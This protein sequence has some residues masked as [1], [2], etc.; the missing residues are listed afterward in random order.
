MP[1]ADGPRAFAA[2]DDGPASDDQPV[3]RTSFRA[4]AVRPSASGSGRVV[5]SPKAP[6]E[7]SGS[8]KRNQP[9]RQP[10]SKRGK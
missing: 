3:E 8:A 9:S 2:D 5:P 10:R 7:Q 1:V 6:V 4:P